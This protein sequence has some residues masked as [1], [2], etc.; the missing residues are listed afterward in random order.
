M[1]K[2]W[3]FDVRDMDASVRPQDDFYHY[4]AGGWLAR[5]PIP[6]SEARWGSFMALRYDTDRKLRTILAELESMKRVVRGTPEQL[7]RDFYR[8]G[9]DMKRRNAL[10]TKPLDEF[11]ARIRALKTPKDLLDTVAALHRIGVGVLWGAGVDQDSKD[12]T[13]YILH[14][15]QDG[16]SLPDRDYYLKDDAESKRVREAYEPYVVRMLG[17]MGRSRGQARMDADIIVR[18]E[19]ELAKASMSKE[20]RRDADLVYHKKSRREL[21]ALASAIDWNRYFTKISA[22]E[23][24]SVIVMQTEFLKRASAMLHEISLDDWKVYLEWHLVNEYA[25]YLSVSFVRESFSFYGT[26]LSGTKVMKPLWRRTLNAVNATLGEPLGRIYVKKHF[27]KDAKRKMHALVEDLFVAYAAR[28]KNLDWM[29]PA[30]KKKALKKLAAMNRKIGYPDK[31]KSSAGLSIRPDEFAGNALRAEEFEHKKE[32]RKLQK[33]IDRGEWFMYPQTVN[34]YFAPN[35]NDIV[36]PAAILQPPFF[37]LTADDAVNYAAIGSVIGHEITHGFDDQG[38]KYD[39]KGN[40]KSWWTLADRAKFDKKAQIIVAQYS[41]Y[42]VADGVPVNGQLT[43]G[44]NIADLGGIAIAFDAYQLRLQ[45]TGRQD[46]GGLTP[47]QRFF[48]S[49]TL[50]E[51]ESARPEFAKMQVLTDPHSPAKFRING[52]VSNVPAF[53]EAFKVKKGDALYREPTVR[54]TVW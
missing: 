31:W 28:L 6:E 16:L 32:M 44:E 29:T 43:L 39:E 40:L 50:F 27:S 47:E 34:A 5:N 25:G 10:G 17:R 18:I 41:Q 20:D 1:K 38:S 3:G 36:F 22:G 4:A 54:T 45:K 11:R 42:R 15:F 49:L 13:K 2:N 37:N 19:T 12:S 9:L 35:L 24:K 30:T 33:P 8:S 7:I 46:I 53:Y 52:P 23:P 48:L 21:A 26:V 51:R 14:I